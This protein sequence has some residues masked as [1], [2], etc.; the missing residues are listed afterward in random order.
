MGYWESLTENG[1]EEDTKIK[2]DKEMYKENL[3]NWI[4]RK[5]NIKQD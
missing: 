5:I 1:H 2:T 4:L 3:T